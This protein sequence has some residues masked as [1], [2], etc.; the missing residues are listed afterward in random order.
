L[1]IWPISAAAQHIPGL[2][3]VP[4]E[5]LEGRQVSAE[6]VFDVCGEGLRGRF[7]GDDGERG[8][9]AKWWYMLPWPTPARS[10]MAFG[11]VPV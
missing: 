1:A 11:L 5:P 2:Q 6:S 7:E 3:H 4:A 8:L 9:P 10:W